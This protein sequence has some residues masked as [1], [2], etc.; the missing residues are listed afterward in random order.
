[1]KKILFTLKVFFVSFEF[2]VIS[3][4][5]LSLLNYPQ[6]IKN[7][8]SQIESNNE[9]LKFLAI[10]PIGIFVWI[11]KEARELLFPGEKINNILHEWPEYW[12]LR[13][14]FNVA[15]FYSFIFLALG[16]SVWIFGLDINNEIGFVL[17]IVSIIGSFIDAISVYF[18]KVKQEEIMLR[19]GTKK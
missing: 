11:I 14:H 12:K 2:L 5:L 19:L 13:I 3:L 16:L 18:G 7:I 4:C 8:A 15:L 17:L 1:M 10:I 6:E 9:I